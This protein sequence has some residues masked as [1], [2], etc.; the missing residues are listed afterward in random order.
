MTSIIYNDDLAACQTAIVSQAAENLAQLQQLQTGSAVLTELLST[1]V[2]YVDALEQLHGGWL[3]K[4]REV[5]KPL[6]S[7]GSGEQQLLDTVGDLVTMHRGW[8]FQAW[9]IANKTSEEDSTRSRSGSKWGG[10][11]AASQQMPSSS[12]IQALATNLLMVHHI[13]DENSETTTELLCHLRKLANWVWRAY[14]W[15]MSTIHHHTYVWTK[16][17]INNPDSKVQRVWKDLN[18][19]FKPHLK[20]AFASP[21]TRLVSYGMFADR[22]LHT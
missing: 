22:Y 3:M 16:G 12:R 7:W 4:L 20:L 13:G 18:N 15:Y 9:F 21:L 8:L 5:L 2:A 11:R 6:G 1:E 19:K 10:V 14:P 17:L